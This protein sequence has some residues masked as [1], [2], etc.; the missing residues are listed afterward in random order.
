MSGQ[1]ASLFWPLPLVNHDLCIYK[2]NNLGVAI[3]L[4]AHLKSNHEL[5]I[6]AFKS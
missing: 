4:G 3:F 6:Q 5:E 2:D 1:H